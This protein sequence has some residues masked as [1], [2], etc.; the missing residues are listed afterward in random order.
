MKGQ[1]IN[2]NNKTNT[3]K[4]PEKGIFILTI[5]TSRNKHQRKVINL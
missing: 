1:I 2:K 3:I 5:T 4:I